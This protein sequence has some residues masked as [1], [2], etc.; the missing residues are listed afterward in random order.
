MKANELRIGNWV[1]W[2]D[3]T[4]RSQVKGIHPSGK[5]A[6]LENGWV[7]LI[8]CDSIPLTEEWLVKFGFEFTDWLGSWDLPDGSLGILK[9]NNDTFILE[10]YRCPEIQYVN[11]LQNLYFALTGEELQLK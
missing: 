6:H 5:Y 2:D 3:K 7:D 4:I 9:T 11:Q 1:D 8:R 10:S